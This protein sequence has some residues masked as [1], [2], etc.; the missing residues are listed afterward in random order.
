MTPHGLVFNVYEDL[1][2]YADYIPRRLPG[3]HRVATVLRQ[4]GW[5][6]E[7]LDFTIY[8]TLEELK[9]Y[10]RSRITSQ[11]KFVGFSCFFGT[12]TDT[13]EQ[14]AQWL[15][16]TYPSITRL[17]GGTAF[18]MNESS[19]ID[20]HFV[21]FSEKAMLTFVEVMYGSRPR[22]DLVFDPKYLGKK[23]VINSNTHYPAFPMSDLNI[24][25]EDRDY[26]NENEW[27]TIEMARGCMFKCK[28]CNFPIL[29]VKG[30]HTR[31]ADDFYK[32][33]QE[34]YDRYGIKNYY[35]SEETFNDRSDKLVKFA[36]AVQQLSFDPFF[37]G[38]IRADLMVSRPEDKEHLLRMNFL[39]HFYGIE[40]TNPETLKVVG[41]G[42]HP[43]RLMS[44][45]VEA[46]KYFQSHGRQ[47]YRATTS[48][49]VGLPHETFKSLHQTVQWIKNNW[50]DQHVLWFPL[51]IPL[52]KDGAGILS[53]LSE[54]PGKYGYEYY[55]G[56]VE[57]HSCLVAPDLMPWKN[58]HMHQGQAQKFV[59]LFYSQW[60]LLRTLSAP[61]ALGALA[62]PGVSIDEQLKNPETPEVHEGAKQFGR[63][64]VAD[65]KQKK[66]K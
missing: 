16:S 49:I 9:E 44:G 54:N 15:K 63:Q 23:K 2:G 50:L 37:A 52:Q 57:D 24:Y 34:T 42:M 56:F 8:F 53:D 21:G 47:I 5:D 38:Y 58:Q 41:K 17:V 20:Y 30:D 6:V 18:V 28:F 12:W 60:P 39:G 65:Y 3:G 35:V 40:S 1:Q 22:S 64:F 25:Y 4:H 36:D 13:V 29:G 32:N 59:G 19:A 48:F 66:L 62:R 10:A 33:L 55:D 7:V 11:T 27:L 61:F 14:F 31:S 43:D 45:I 26:L 51:E 46:K